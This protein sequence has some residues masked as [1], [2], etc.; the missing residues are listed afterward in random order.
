MYDTFWQVLYEH[1]AEIVLNGHEHLYERFEPMNPDG[2]PDATAGTG[3]YG[4][5]W[6]WQPAR[7]FEDIQPKQRSA[8]IR[9]GSAQVNP[10]E[11]TAMTG[12]FW[13]S[14]QKQFP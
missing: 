12:S 6:R 2:D 11:R 7:V 5:N 10:R 1:G 8:W 14:N 9:M 4:G 13:R 3:N